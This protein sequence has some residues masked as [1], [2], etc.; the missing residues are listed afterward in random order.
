MTSLP[1]YYI[2]DRYGDKPLL[3]CLL[4]GAE[5]ELSNCLNRRVTI[6]C[7]CG[8][9]WKVHAYEPPRPPSVVYDVK[10]IASPK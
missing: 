4:C 7:E 9:S 5:H 8:T 3:I 6:D 1:K 2:F 10:L